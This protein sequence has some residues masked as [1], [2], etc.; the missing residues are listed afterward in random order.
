[1]ESA[2]P[3][4][5]EKWISVGTSILAPA[6]VLT[7]LLFY[8]G[9]ASSHAKYAF[10]G[11]DVNLVG[12]STQ[13]YALSSPQAL[14]VPVLVLLL[15]TIMLIV[16]H[17][18]VDRTLTRQSVPNS[19]TRAT[20]IVRFIAIA[21]L[22]AG[23]VLML[24]YPVFRSWPYYELITPLTLGSSMGITT[25]THLLLRR[26][27]RVDSG[28]PAQLVSRASVST[29]LPISRRGLLVALTW[30]VIA[31]T[32][33]WTTTTVASWSGRGQARQLARDFGGLP[34]VIL[35]TKERLWLH[36]PF[37]TET[38]LPLTTGQIYHYRYRNLRLLIEGD[39]RLFLVPERWS[40]SDSTLVVPFDGSIRIQF[41]FQNP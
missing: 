40:P 34:R 18:A 25:Y 17:G 27:I 29:A 38:E 6:T 8:Y 21:S 20:M 11:L 2:Q 12:L 5:T 9:Y 26:I 31:L 24:A 16:G 32:L 7:S 10:F 13:D 39:G 30:A 14:V 3:S 36:D 41:Q 4:V 15:T 19:L 33:F 1:M 35:D 37:V 28:A 22:A 23:L